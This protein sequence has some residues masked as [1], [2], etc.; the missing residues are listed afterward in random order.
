V[1]RRPS[2]SGVAQDAGVMVDSKRQED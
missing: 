2:Q 1:H